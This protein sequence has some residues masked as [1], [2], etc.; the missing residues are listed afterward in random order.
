MA[1]VPRVIGPYHLL[2]S[3]GEGGMGVVYL[4]E[5][6]EPLVR[7][8]A[9][10]LIKPGMATREVLARFEAERQALA[11]MDHPHIARVLDAGLGP[12]HRP[13]FVMEYVAGLPLTDY[14]D[15]H[16]LRNAERLQ[17]FLP[18][19][20]A[21]Q[22]A[23]QKGVI[24][25]DL[26]PSNI[27]VALQDGKPVPKVI[28]FG[29]A[30]ATCQ[31]SVERAAFTQF[32]MLIG[33]PE[34]M[35]PEQAEASGLEVDTTTDI[36]S[37]GVILYELLTGVLPFDAETLRRAGYLEMHR[38]IREQ[39]PPKPSTRVTALGATA[40]EVARHHQTTPPALGKQLRGDLDAIAL[41]AMEKDRTRRYASASEFAADITR[42]LHG[43]AVVA[44]PPS[45]L[46][47]TRKFARRHKV[48]VAAGTLVAAALVVGLAL[49]TVFYVK[50]ERAR[51]EAKEQ[52][53]AASISS[54]DLLAAADQP[55]DARSRLSEVPRRGWEWWYLFHKTDTSIDTLFPHG[56]FREF[57]FRSS[58]FVFAADES[59]LLWNTETTI[60]AWDARTLAPV[61]VYGGFGT[62]L[63]LAP[64]GALAITSGT[65]PT[66]DYAV[67]VIEPASG[68]QVASLAGNESA[69]ACASL[70]SDPPRAATSD[71]KTVR[72]WDVTSGKS[73]AVIK[74]GCPVAFS[75]DRR[76]IASMKEKG[77]AQITD[78]ETGRP[79]VTLDD[80]ASHVGAVAF[81]HGGTLIATSWPDGTIRT[82][83]LP[84]GVLR[85]TMR[86]HAR[87]VIALAFS[88]DDRRL[89]SAA[90]DQ[91]ARVWDVQSGDETGRCAGFIQGTLSVAFDPEG[92]RFLVA[93]S[94]HGRGAEIRVFDSDAIAP[95]RTLT[96]EASVESAAFSPDGRQ[97][98]SGTADGKIVLWDASTLQR[99][100]VLS[101]HTSEV[102]AVAYHLSDPRIASGS[103]DDTVRVW[104]TGSGRL[105]GTFEGHHDGVTAVAFSPRGTEIASSSRDGLVLVRDSLSG[106]VLGRWQ[107]KERV[108][109]VRFDR[110]GTRLAIGSGDP[111]RMPSPDGRIRLWDWK[112]GNVTDSAELP[113]KSAVQSVAVNPANGR[114]AVAGSGE[115][116]AILWDSTLTRKVGTLHPSYSRATL[117][118]SP[119]GS[120]IVSAS[121]DGMVR[122]ADAR[123]LRPLLNLSI[124][125]G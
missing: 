90:W 42:Y 93:G 56:E 59:R 120:R 16:R 110:T 84:T 80:S 70:S 69:V 31:G 17:L 95:W 102:T 54:A 111:S 35:S 2:Q 105:V 109:T 108:S 107:G 46:Y 104:D 113:H 32:G 41:K 11:L 9:L 106:T 1:D 55:D 15:R 97:I 98:A 100:S 83:S 79:V 7:R 38:I 40:A 53:Y 88:P 34:Y 75:A 39:D 74:G 10:K 60:H 51:T 48:G 6:R 37:L 3:L 103:R 21:L 76:W 91:T 125:V 92:R 57:P 33:T 18:V 4:A 65:A 58:S 22:H 73:L 121:A 29:I 101:G 44:R 62:I 72:T 117:A 52:A 30:K 13:Y 89:A 78:A 63:A 20:A 96:H 115:P 67:R 114:I 119:D 82:W 122:V 94:E 50:S 25:R 27:L 123:T 43:E 28:D 61:V 8:V 87:Y 5:Q 118:F 19:C 71:R 47:R 26:K 23:H 99:V 68:R 49:S 45:V 77:G 112:A 12:H 64:S 66:T 86:G 14:C 36:Y 124:P 116:D 24:H 81:G 85:S